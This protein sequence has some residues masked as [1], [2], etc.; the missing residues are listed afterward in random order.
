VLIVDKDP[1]GTNVR[2]A[3]GGK[4]VKVV[5]FVSVESPR[6]VT[7]DGKSGEWFHVR[8]DGEEGWMHRSVL[9][10]CSGGTEDGD[11]SLAKGPSYDSGQGP[12]IP[13]GTPVGL[14]D[15]KNEWLK[16]EYVDARGDVV[17]GWLPEQA[18]VMS[19]SDVEE[20]AKAWAF[21]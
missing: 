21:K 10:L 14:L 2:D 3:P 8:A 13:Y 7:V 11:P 9:G 18:I 1:K 12:F 4:V 19:E 17:V 15:M 16:L 6:T 5:P 20:C